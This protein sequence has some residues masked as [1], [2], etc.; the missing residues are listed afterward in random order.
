MGG[1]E[2]NGRVSAQGPAT[3]T[4]MAVDER[5]WDI[6]MEMEMYEAPRIEEVGSVAATTRGD[7]LG[8]QDD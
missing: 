4:S 3:A 6:G 1:S 2:G 7:G 5:S 8:G